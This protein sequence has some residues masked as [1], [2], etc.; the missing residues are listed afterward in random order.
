MDVK[1]KQ[2]KLKNKTNKNNIIKIL[3]VTKSFEEGWN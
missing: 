1:N 3:S 2:T